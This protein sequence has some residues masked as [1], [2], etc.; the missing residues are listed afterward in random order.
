MIALSLEG[1]Q[2]AVCETFLQ[3]NP[4][5]QYVNVLLYSLMEATYENRSLSQLISSLW[6]IRDGADTWVGL[7]KAPFFIGIISGCCTRGGGMCPPSVREEKVLRGA[8]GNW[9]QD[10]YSIISVTVSKKNTES[11]WPALINSWGQAATLLWLHSL[12]YKTLPCG[13]LHMWIIMVA[14][15]KDCTS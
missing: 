3:N 9:W 14:I 11:K 1:V 13:L 12:R 4:D 8:K 7:P 15:K 5:S 6:N 2:S 10:T